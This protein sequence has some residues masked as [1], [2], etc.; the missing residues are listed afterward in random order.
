MQI[1]TS[2]LVRQPLHGP[3]KPQAMKFRVVVHHA[4]VVLQI[5]QVVLVEQAET[6]RNPSDSNMAARDGGGWRTNILHPFQLN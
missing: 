6:F 1:D 2:T 4:L 5:G 3:D